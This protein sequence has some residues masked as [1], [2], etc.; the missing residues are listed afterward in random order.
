MALGQEVTSAREQQGP[1]SKVVVEKQT[2]VNSA[3]MSPDGKKRK[4][5]ITELR[6]IDSE[7]RGKKVGVQ[8]RSNGRG[9]TAEV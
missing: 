1:R 5:L 7:E 2:L 3:V 8:S 4:E 9:V 6:R